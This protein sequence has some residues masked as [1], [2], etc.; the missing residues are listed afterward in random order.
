M[1]PRRPEPEYMNLSDEVA[2][3]AGAD[4]AE[5]NEAF[6]NRLLELCGDRPIRSLLDLCTGPG[7]IPLRLKSRRPRWRIVGLDA[8][9]GMLAYGARAMK[10][11]GEGRLVAF[12][13]GDVKRLP[14]RDGT[15][16]VVASNSSLHHVPDPLDFWREV[17]RVAGRGALVFVRDLRRPADT[18]A[19][20]R[21]V[22]T[23][24]AHESAL[25]QEEYFRSLLAAFT[26]EEVQLQLRDAGLPAFSVTEPTDRHLDVS[27]MLP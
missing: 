27:G 25:L 18:V 4:F 5:V 11:N 14:F 22:E 19:A 26:P 17:R 12:V 15:F 20:R 10:E 7:D 2:A 1:M 9:Y 21:I 24:A 16:D 3:Y 6:V 8:S 13:Q 23:Y